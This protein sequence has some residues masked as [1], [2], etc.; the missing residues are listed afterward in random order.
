[1]NV[2]PLVVDGIVILIFVACIFDGYR[3]GFVKMLLSIIAVSLSLLLANVLSAPL[4]QWVN[5]EYVS[6][7]VSEY[8]DDY[9]DDALQNVGLSGDELTG[10]S[11]EGA[12]DE[13]I[14][15]I[16]E[17]INQLLEQYDISVEDIL[18]DISAEDTLEKT[19]ERIKENIEQAIII[20]VLE[21]VAFLVAYLVCFII[22][23]IIA[24]FIS[25]LIVL[26]GLKDINKS[27]GAALGTVKGVMV[28][29]VVCIFAVLAASFFPGNEFADAVSE[30]ILTNTINEIA[31]GVIS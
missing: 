9:V 10:N 3:R 13:I 26:P 31:L 6:D 7:I 20:P 22:L 28:I 23:S 25:S 5:D 14:E 11:F 18:K 24:G 1:M 17:E 30:A 15:A 29:A 4:A 27:L 21:I 2:L 16:P 19:G 12:E 8:I